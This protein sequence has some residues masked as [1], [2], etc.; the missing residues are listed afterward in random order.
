MKHI[1]TPLLMLMM[2]TL[3]AWATLGEY[4]GSVTL[5]QQ[6][7]RGEDRQE[8][9]QGYHLHQIT[10]PDGSFVREYVTPEGKVFGI[11]WQGRSLPNLQ[12]LLGSYM[13]NLQ[14]AEKRTVPRRSLVVRTDTFVFMSV[15]HLGTFQGHAYVPGL[16]PNNL[17]PEVVQ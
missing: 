16:I 1:F 6:Y 12:Q 2:G 3:P 15:G 10:T 11:S 14:Q 7:I 17:R 9:R 8:V 4:E 13:T 5:D